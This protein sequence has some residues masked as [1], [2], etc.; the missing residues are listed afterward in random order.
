MIIIDLT[1]L[2]DNH[3]HRE[4]VHKGEEGELKDK[5]VDKVGDAERKDNGHERHGGD[6]DGRSVEDH[7]DN[8]K[9]SAE[10]Y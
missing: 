4:D 3:N 7:A 1:R 9:E 10:Q 6:K 2:T 8:H 5:L